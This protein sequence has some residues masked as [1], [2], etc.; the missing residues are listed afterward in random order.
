[1]FVA[2]NPTR[3]VAGPDHPGPVMSR[4]VGLA[5][6]CRLIEI[7]QLRVKGSNEHGTGRTGNLGIAP[8]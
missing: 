1:M 3:T 6:L 4:R 8:A 7:G 5:D 2:V